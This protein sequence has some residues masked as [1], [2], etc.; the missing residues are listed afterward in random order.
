MA[1][2]QGHGMTIKLVG[3]QVFG[4]VE[5]K[6]GWGDVFEKRGD[7]DLGWKSTPEGKKELAGAVSIFFA[8]MPGGVNTIALADSF[9][10]VVRSGSTS[11][12]RWAQAT[13]TCRPNMSGVTPTR[14]SNSGARPNHLRPSPPIR[15]LS[16][17]SRVRFRSSPT[18][19]PTVRRTPTSPAPRATNWATISGLADL[20]NAGDFPAE[21]TAREAGAID[22]MGES[23]ALPHF[24]LANRIAL[25]WIDPA[26]LRRFDFTADPN[27]G[28]VRLQAIETVGMDGP[29]DARVA[30]IEVPITDDWSYLF[31]YR[32]EQPGQL[33][34]HNL[35][36]DVV[37]TD[38]KALIGTDLRWRGGD[39]A[40]PPILRLPEDID[41]DGPV[42][43][44]TGRNYRDNDVTNP[45]R[46]HD[47]VLTLDTIAPPFDDD[48]AEVTVEYLEAHRPQLMVHPAPGNG[49][50]RSRDIRLVSRLRERHADRRKGRNQLHRG[51]CAQR[52]VARRD[53][54]RASGSSGCRSP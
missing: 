3:D 26:W 30:G 35:H 1:D 9:V 51:H 49:N 53:G 21:V 27:G 33:D 38:D 52:R 31:E 47:F 37:R 20:Y 36:P 48:S 32:R 8:D 7:P 39:V 12:F 17:N 11:R 50:F 16:H 43:N 25:G 4:P 24:S 15:P 13:Q 29:I 5:V 22:L 18:N 28:S 10:F 46:M 44:I 23:Q 6:H 40:R 14:R 45:E 42:L 19:S 41:G 54:C 2:P 34:D